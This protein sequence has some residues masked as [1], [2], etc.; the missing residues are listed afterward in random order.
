M[1]PVAEPTKC[2]AI[3]SALVDIPVMDVTVGRSYSWCAHRE[4]ANSAEGEQRDGQDL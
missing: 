2:A 3:P 1:A 4:K